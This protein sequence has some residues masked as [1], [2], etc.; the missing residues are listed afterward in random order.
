M[1]FKRLCLSNNINMYII[2]LLFTLFVVSVST[3]ELTTWEHTYPDGT[4]IK[5]TSV[6]EGIVRVKTLPRGAHENFTSVDLLLPQPVPAPPLSV[7]S[8]THSGWVIG[9][10]T[11]HVVVSAHSAVSNI[12]R[13]DGTLLSSELV[14]PVK[15]KEETFTFHNQLILFIMM[16]FFSNVLVMFSFFFLRVF[17]K[18]EYG[19]SSYKNSMVIE[20]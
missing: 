15:L 16:F 5:V 7:I 11:L 19:N 4:T 6:A 1:D 9:T 18:Y 14:P 17:L 12:T 2:F 3:S 20:F 10:D 8:T 13:P